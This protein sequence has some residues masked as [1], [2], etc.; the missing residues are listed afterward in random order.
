MKFPSDITLY[1][2]HSS[3]PEIR[4]AASTGGFCKSFLVFLVETGR[5]DCAIITRS[6]EGHPLRPETI[7]TDRVEDIVSTRTNSIYA[8][9][10]P[11]SILGSLESKKS[12]AFVGLPC[13]CKALKNMQG[14]GRY[15]N[16]RVMVCLFCNYTPKDDFTL[17]RLREL[18]VSI[19]DVERIEYRG[20][21]WP[22]KFTVF[23]K[24]GSRRQGVHKF[25]DLR[26][27]PGPCVRCPILP[28]DFDISAGD[29]WNLGLEGRDTQ[30]ATLVSVRG[31]EPNSLVREA[32]R[33]GYIRLLTDPPADALER[34]QRSSFERKLRNRV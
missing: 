33:A 4:F 14:R 5:V 29:P 2:A 22:G 7:A 34:S 28:T 16:I 9:P 10:K 13:H 8:I 20:N 3:D 21:G 19:G 32:E 24:D 25:T 6:R 18:G 11:L 1:Y 15:L 23:L 17:W 31:G 26:Y 27:A 12:Y 30:G